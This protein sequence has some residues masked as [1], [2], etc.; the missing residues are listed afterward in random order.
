MLRRAKC[1]S[2]SGSAGGCQ[3]L[4]ACIKVRRGGCS[5]PHCSEQAQSMRLK[6]IL[7]GAPPREP[8]PKGSCEHRRT[9][10]CT[11]GAGCLPSVPC[12]P[13]SA[14]PRSQPRPSACVGKAEPGSRGGVSQIEITTK[15]YSFTDSFP[16]KRGG[17]AGGRARPGGATCGGTAR[18]RLGAGQ[19]PRRGAGPGG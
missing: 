12:P 2:P 19:R 3:S 8:S 10:L 6:L 1:C 15:K 16:G 7:T 13:R 14:G 4:P 18:P 5:N 17:G 11:N 9:R